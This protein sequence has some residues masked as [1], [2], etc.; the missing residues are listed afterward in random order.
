MVCILDE[1]LGPD[2]GE[3]QMSYA[4]VKL[5]LA[6]VA[7]VSNSPAL[8]AWPSDAV[9]NV[10]MCVAPHMQFD[11]AAVCDRRG[12]IVSAWD[13]SRVGAQVYASHVA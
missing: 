9:T 4:V 5:S 11:P 6:I 7:L 8:A 13:D 12:G 2:G 10:P 1:T 3:I